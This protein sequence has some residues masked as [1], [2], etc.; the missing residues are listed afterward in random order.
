MALGKK[1]KR[2]LLIA[3]ALALGT[4]VVVAFVKSA[5]AGSAPSAPYA[6]DSDV[7]KVVD[8]ALVKE[9]D[10]AILREL[11]RAMMIFPYS[12]P[13]RNKVGVLQARA[14]ELEASHQAVQQGDGSATRRLGDFF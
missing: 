12:N 1:T 11:A 4:G 10:P 3:G 14:T 7:Q 13:L 9:T 6:S 8:A 2:N 5:S